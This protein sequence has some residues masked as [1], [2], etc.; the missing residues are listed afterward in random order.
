[1][2]TASTP[3]SAA[4]RRLA[5]LLVGGGDGA[6]ASGMAPA[7][8]ASLAEARGYADELRAA[9]LAS[10]LPAGSAVRPAVWRV[11]LGAPQCTAAEYAALVA[12]GPSRLAVDIGKDLHRTLSSDPER[13]TLAPT[14]IRSRLLNALVHWFDDGGVA[15][16]YVQGMGALAMLMTHVCCSHRN[17]VGGGDVEPAL[18]AAVCPTTEVDAFAL[19]RSVLTRGLPTWFTA[20]QPAVRTACSLAYRVLCEVDDEVARF[21]A[22]TYGPTTAHV[23][24]LF[25]SRCSSLYANRPPLSAI[26]QLWDAILALGVHT[27]VLLCA[28]EVVLRRDEL[29]A[30]GRSAVTRFQGE[31][32]RCLSVVVRVAPAAIGEASSPSD[33]Y[34]RR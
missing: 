19:L 20:G 21:F 28:A 34:W 16:G 15:T 17:N 23:E 33:N 31:W 7:G 24:L 13:E 6:G 10:G 9:L 8:A 4:E 32:V 14:A 11:L 18:A 25:Y 1:M 26:T 30:A 5:A 2:A 22:D 27:V 3:L 12:R 29:M